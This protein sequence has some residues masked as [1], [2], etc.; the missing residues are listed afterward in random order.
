MITRPAR[1]IMTCAITGSV[2]D[3]TA[4]QYLPITPEQ[5]ANSA[6]EAADAGATIVH[7]HV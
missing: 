7:L 5:I 1:T 6:L 2:T 3:P 4:T